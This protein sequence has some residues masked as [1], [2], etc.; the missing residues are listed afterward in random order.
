[1]LFCN[2][3]FQVVPQL[4][5]QKEGRNLSETYRA[6][7]GEIV[8][9]NCVALGSRPSFEL[10]WKSTSEDNI[11]YSET[12]S[13]RNEFETSTVNLESNLKIVV[14]RSMILTCYSSSTSKFNQIQT[15]LNVTIDGNNSSFV[16]VI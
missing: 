12:V 14:E 3:I 16:Y 11:S 15:E 10:L 7:F 13:K 8:D 4:I 2:F 5:I 1:M 9:L 6:Y